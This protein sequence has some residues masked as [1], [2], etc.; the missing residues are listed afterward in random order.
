MCQDNFEI[1]AIL[2]IPRTNTKTIKCILTLNRF[3]KHLLIMYENKTTRSAF[4]L[5]NIKIKFDQ[6]YHDM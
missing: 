4:M 5:I 3:K 1:T 6:D 2:L